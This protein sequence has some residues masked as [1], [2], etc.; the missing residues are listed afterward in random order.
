[1]TT[2]HADN[3]QPTEQPSVDEPAEQTAA[4]RRA[5]AKQWFADHIGQP[6]KFR[7]VAERRLTYARHGDYTHAGQRPIRRTI[8]VFWGRL[9]VGKK[10]A[11][12]Y[13]DWLTEEP[14]RFLYSLIAAF[15][16]TNAAAQIPYVGDLVAYIPVLH[17][18]DVQSWFD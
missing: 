5:R 7:P 15:V 4:A 14:G 3:A 16:L 2:P 1:M 13:F 10:A 12:C 6:P 11:L 8:G 9:D 18:F 17:Y